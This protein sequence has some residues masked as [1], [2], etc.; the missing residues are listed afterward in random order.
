VLV[1]D[2]HATNRR[3]VE[4]ILQSVGAE[5]VS[6]ADGAEALKAFTAGPFDL[7]LMDMQMPVMDGLSAIRAIRRVEAE[8]GL[9]R[10][11]VLALTANALPEHVRASL[12]A[13]ADGHIAKPIGA[14]MLL[15]G[16][17]AAL[18]TQGVRRAL[19]S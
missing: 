14:A 7:V 9:P 4:L 2:D 1:A 16:V 17:A 11:S 6:V 18:G 10:T 19:A 8:R 13:G 15:E 12:A 5:L 3:V